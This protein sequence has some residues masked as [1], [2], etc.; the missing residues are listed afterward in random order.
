MTDDYSNH[1]HPCPPKAKRPRN[2][3]RKNHNNNQD[4]LKQLSH[5]LSWAL[6]HQAIQLK[7]TMRTDGFVPLVEILKSQ[8]PKLRGYTQ[9]QVEAV[10]QNN[11]KQRFALQQKPAIDYADS[12]FVHPETEEIIWCIRANQGHSLPK[13]VVDPEQ[14]LTALTPEQL[15][16]IPCIVHGTSMEA[17]KNIQDAGYLSRMNRQHIHFA[18]GLPGEVI[19]G[20]RKSSQVYIYVDAV[21]CA[22]E[23]ILFYESANEVLLTPGKQDGKLSLHY[24]ARVTTSSG[25]ILH[26]QNSTK[27]QG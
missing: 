23:G 20:M 1:Y 9:E 24:I 6:R 2:N 4:P 13:H 14:L 21:K 16:N 10:V 12:P 18:K 22:D 5:A 26:D 7:L 11:D 3:R 8:H 27:Q 19:S 25:E 17:W 15:K